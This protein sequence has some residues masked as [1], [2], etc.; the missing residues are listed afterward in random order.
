MVPLCLCSPSLRAVTLRWER[1]EGSCV[2][3]V[4][5]REGGEVTRLVYVMA[6]T[7]EACPG[8]RVNRG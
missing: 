5:Q 6:V 2:W 4:L 3:L 7:K 1:G 8:S